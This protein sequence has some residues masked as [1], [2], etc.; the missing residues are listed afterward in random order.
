MRTH[1]EVILFVAGT[2]AAAG[3]GEPEYSNT[4][5]D[6]VSASQTSGNNLHTERVTKTENELL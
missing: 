3:S 4:T 2:G 5:Y 1:L 6:F